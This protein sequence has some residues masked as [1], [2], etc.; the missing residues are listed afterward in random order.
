[1]SAS[2]LSLASLFGGGSSEEDEEE[3]IEHRVKQASRAPLGDLGSC[4]SFSTSRH[5][6]SERRRKRKNVGRSWVSWFTSNE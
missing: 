3:E 2:A 5:L 4:F 1:M 6:R